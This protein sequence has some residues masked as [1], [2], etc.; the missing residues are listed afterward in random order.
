MPGLHGFNPA[1]TDATGL[2]PFWAATKTKAYIL[3]DNS[4]SVVVVTLSFIDSFMTTGQKPPKP[5]DIKALK[6]RDITH[7]HDQGEHGFCDE[8]YFTADLQ[9]D[10]EHELIAQGLAD[11]NPTAPASIKTCQGESTNTCQAREQEQEPPPEVSDKIQIHS[12]VVETHQTVPRINEQKPEKES[13]EIIDKT[14]PSQQSGPSSK[15]IQRA[16]PES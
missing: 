13:S 6:T 4:L 8:C 7:V 9:R 11:K 15:K 3:W 5:N 1:I 10:L 2:N 12:T 16:V 14:L